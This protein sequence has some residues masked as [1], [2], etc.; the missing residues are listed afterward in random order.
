ML[1]RLA[2]TVLVAAAALT[3]QP[4]AWAAGTPAD[5]GAVTADCPPGQTPVQL[6][7]A[8][9]AGAELGTV[10]QWNPDTSWGG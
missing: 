9:V 10:G 2:L 3:V 5:T 1:K 6:T 4:A 8:P 7:A